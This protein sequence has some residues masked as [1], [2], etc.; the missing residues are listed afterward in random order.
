MMKL[1]HLLVGFTLVIAIS[2]MAQDLLKNGDFENGLSGWEIS[3]K[4]L[5]DTQNKISGTQALK[6]DKSAGKGFDEIYQ[7]ISLK[8]D[9]EYELSY[10]VKGQD[11][12]KTV[13]QANVY[14]VSCTLAAG[15]RRAYGCDG[16]WKYDNGT[17]DWR[18]VVVRFNSNDFKSDTLR[19]GIQFPNA[20]GIAWIDAFSISESQKEAYRITLFPIKY[21]DTSPYSIAENLVG[22]IFLNSAPE[23]SGKKYSGKNYSSGTTAVM[24]FEMPEFVRLA[25]VTDRMILKNQQ[26]EYTQT[27]YP[28][29]ECK[30]ERDGQTYRRYTITFDQ[31]MLSLLGARWYY[32]KIFLLPEAESA[33]KKGV[34]AWSFKIGEDRQAEEKCAIEI[35]PAI[36]HHAAACRRFRLDIGYSAVDNSPFTELR[37]IMSSFWKNLSVSPAS[38]LDM[39]GGVNP[40]YAQKLVVIGDD[41]M[42]DFPFGRE[43][44]KAY[45]LKAPAN[46]DVQ[47]RKDQTPSWYKL[48]DPER[49]YENYLRA[50]IREA[51]KKYPRIAAFKWDYEPTRGGYDEEGRSRFAKSLQLAKTPSID[52]IQCDYRA[53]WS[54]YTYELNAKFIAK[55]AQIFKE[56][57]PD[58]EFILTTAELRSSGSHL[59]RWCDVDIRLVDN[60]PNIDTIEGMPYHTGSEFF[61][62]IDFNTK[63]IKKPM[64]FA[65]DPSERIWSYFQKYTPDRVRQNIVAVAALG[66]KGVCHWPDDSMKAEYYK[67]FADAYAIISMYENVYFD[68]KRVDDDFTLTPQNVISMEIAGDRGK[69][70]LD[71]PDF[72]S[73]TRMAVHEFKGDFY[74]TIFNY[75]EA[76]PVI[77]EVS[78]HGKTFLAEI[79]PA[80]VEVIESAKL[81]DQASVRRRLAEFKSKNSHAA[82]QELHQGNLSAAWALGSDNSPVF[83]LSN[84]QVFVDIN[85]CGE[86]ELVGLRGKNG[87]DLFLGGAGARIIF[88]D[89][90]QPP[91]AF[92]ME[93]MQIDKDSVSASFSATVPAYEGAIPEQN[94]LQAM[95]II[96]KFTLKDKQL[97]VMLSFYNPTQHDMRLGFRVWNFPQLGARF[98]RKNLSTL[99]GNNRINTKD[100][101]NH[102]FLKT[103]MDIPLGQKALRKHWDGGG[104]FSSASDGSLKDELAVLP[105]SKFV[106]IY[107]WNS[108]GVVPLQTIELLSP[109]VTLSSNGKEDFSYEFVLE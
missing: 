93:D 98:G 2:A 74:F 62:D 81:E 9:T 41:T 96:R 100:A 69:V 36:V 66:G 27:A 83:Q 94:P 51:L 43:A 32:H 68:G 77:L 34:L 104:I 105:S 1:L 86:C 65:Q 91:L 70:K 95:K 48:E 82:V 59:S 20:K 72:K 5:F 67:A 15:N 75:N 92:R 107:V 73:S 39:G 76:E 12:T 54:K 30:I 55:V 87:G 103:E 33:G 17:F 14:G 23:N 35:T 31:R 106:G 25:G 80:G 56:E 85:A 7:F 28:F 57:A 71:F 21:L 19:V 63:N 79:P 10:Y 18:K 8:P 64:T 99:I 101:E 3:G 44:T 38:Q 45:R 42:L 29:A 102:I 26:G 52:E 50:S 11:I 60:D 22:T 109:W 97:E 13:E 84:G 40:D 61:D 78:G 49:I 47:G 6:I 88:Y 4:A 46:I 108:Q 24:I 16:L 90:N 37:P 89:P 53:E 58:R